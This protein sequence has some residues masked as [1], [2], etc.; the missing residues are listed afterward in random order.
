MS[1]LHRADPHQRAGRRPDYG[2]ILLSRRDRYGLVLCAEH[3]AI[4]ADLLAAAL[5][6]GPERLRGILARWRK[7][8]LAA[9][10]RLEAGPA[11]CWLTPAGMAAT[12]LGYDAGRPPVTQLGGIRAVLAARLSLE[13]SPV[14]RHGRPWWH[15]DR[16]ILAARPG[17][18][19][20]PVPD[21]E[22]HWPYQSGLPYAGQIWA[23]HAEVT[24][25]TLASTARTMSG[26]LT[27]PDQYGQVLYLTSPAARL[28]VT[29]A[30]AGLP[31]DRQIRVMIR[32]LPATAF[33]PQD[34]PA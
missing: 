16:G 15:S 7:A 32:D 10:G 33:I 11:W 23:L 18:A 22:I 30:A 17:P 25:R 9:T 21:A 2:D 4:P 26:L 8:G 13:A 19:A 12:G 28:V 24:P 5:G 27:G 34:I 29:H 31:P 1:G 6:V 14:F 20:G 3:Y